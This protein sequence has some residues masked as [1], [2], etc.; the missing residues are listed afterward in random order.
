[1]KEGDLRGDQ[2]VFPFG[3]RGGYIRHETLGIVETEQEVGF[4]YRVVVEIESWIS[5]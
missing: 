1:M 4:D 5:G 3:L 2:Y